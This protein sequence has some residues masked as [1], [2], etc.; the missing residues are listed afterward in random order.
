MFFFY[1]Y[2]FDVCVCCLLCIFI[3]QYLVDGELVGLCM[4]LC[5]FG[6]DVSLVIICNIMV[7]LEEVGLVVLLYILVGCIFML[8]GLCLF[9]DS[10]IELQ[11]LVC[12][13]MVWFKLELLL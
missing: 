8:C 3:V 10:L 7:D 9:V 13:D 6:L 11:L 4:L 2:E 5:F 12:D 1:G